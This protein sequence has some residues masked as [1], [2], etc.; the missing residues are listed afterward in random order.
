[1]VRL[2]INLL[3]PI[4]FDYRLALD[5]S[6]DGLV[7]VG[8]VSEAQSWTQNGGLVG[9]GDLPGGDF[10]SR[11]YGVSADGLAI[12]GQGTSA[13]GSEAFR[14]TQSS[15][16][17]GLGILP[18]FDNS[19]AQDVSADG[20]VVVGS[21]GLGTSTYAGAFIWDAVHGMR[22]L[23]DVLINDFGLGAS[24]AG[25][26]LVYAGAISSD[27][28]TVVGY[29]TNPNGDTEAWI[30]RLAISPTLPGDFNNDGAVDAADYV[31][32]RKTDDTPTGY[33]M[34]RAHFGHSGIGAGA[35]SD[36]KPGTVLE[37]TA[38]A[39]IALGLA[40]LAMANTRSGNCSR[41]YNISLPATATHAL[42]AR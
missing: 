3:P 11:A 6:D 8:G 26:N 37:P 21:V 12:V 38:F 41:P 32:W 24:L 19:Q 10:N 16:M 34:W 2:N 5:I 7:I 23:R 35:V 25:W 28:R 33:D 20:S 40:G 17:V 22:N 13:A 27:G 36:S 30:A 31:Y 42:S 14:W 39:L 18:G 15:G 1:M 9:L 4:F 29:G